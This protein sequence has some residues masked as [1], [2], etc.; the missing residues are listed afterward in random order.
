MSSGDKDAHLELAPP[1]TPTH[2]HKL[3]SLV[4]HELRSPLGVV[5]GYLRLLQ[6]DPARPLADA[7]RKFVEEIEKSC[8][9][10][11]DLL[12]EL[13]ELSRLEEGDAP[14]NRSTVE[15]LRL[16]QES[17]AALPPLPDRHVR[18]DVTGEPGH[19]HGDAIRLKAAFTSILLA[20]RREVVTSDCVTVKVRSSA[21][22]V[23]I[24]ICEEARL[25]RLQHAGPHD[26]ATF[27]EWR[28]GNGFG[29]P[30]ARRIIEAHGG[31]I[32]GLRDDR[33]AAATI[34]IPAIPS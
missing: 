7:Q 10:L 12:K 1:P 34:S 3:L 22:Q 27:D 32:L 19:V 5:T 15:I 17:S 16:V 18:I 2:P 11:S 30:I 29:L 20:L 6:K 26:V 13:S 9:K 23:I 4:V 14:F 25:D 33:K 8:A 24:S 21:A 28:G 31:R